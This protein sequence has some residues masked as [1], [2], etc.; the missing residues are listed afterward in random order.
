M[1][2]DFYL[3][4]NLAE[5]NHHELCRLEWREPD[6]DI[7]DALINMVLSRGLAVA[8]DV[9]GLARTRPLERTLLEQ[10]IH[11]RAD[12]HADVG[13]RWFVVGFEHDPL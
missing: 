9:I 10:P 7:D 8:F 4:D 2:S 6:L 11:K 12:V 13:P 1:G 5:A 3:T